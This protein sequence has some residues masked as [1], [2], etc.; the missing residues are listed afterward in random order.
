MSSICLKNARVIT[1]EEAFLGSVLIEDDLIIEVAHGD[2]PFSAIEVL[3]LDGKALFP[4]VVDGHVHF[5]EPGRTSWEGYR[6]GSM[7]AA[8]GG[9]TTFLEMPLNSLPPSINLSSLEQKRHAV[10]NESVVDY[11]N[12]GGLVDNNL[13]DLEAMNAAGVIGY[14]AFTSNSG[15]DFERVNDDLLYAGLLKMRSL[16]NLIGLHAENEFV[17]AYLG[18]QLRTAGRTDRAAW[19]ESRPPDTELE[20]IQRACFWAKATGGNLHIVHVSIAEGINTIE[21]AKQTGSR[22]TSETCPH[23]LFFEHKDFERIGPAAKCAPPIRSRQDVEALW[24]TVLYGLVDIIGSDHSPCSWDEK[25]KG[26]QDIW[27]A[28]GGISGIQVMLP[29]MI[30]E[31]FNRRGL[32]LPAIARMLSFNPAKLFGL[33]PVKGKIQPGADAD[34]VVVDLDK[35]WTLTANQLFYKNKFSAY[36]GSKFKGSVI[37]TLVRGKIVYLDGTIKAHP[38]YGRL[39]K[40]QYP[41]KFP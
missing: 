33:Y 3:D 23:Y 40:R 11:G 39:L 9:V 4:G 2:I 20:A 17:T 36:V 35:E 15:V 38:G 25:E 28:W 12:W 1:E 21:K 30:S 37:Q 7:A 18:S 6:T 19:Y 8:A 41:Y 27:K 29:V 24:E 13:S 22:V 10:S 16:G 14:K 5:N 26:M 31:G 32:P 34:L